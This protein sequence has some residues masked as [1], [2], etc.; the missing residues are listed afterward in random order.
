LLFGGVLRRTLSEILFIYRPD[1][2]AVVRIALA[3]SH[4]VLCSPALKA[5]RY[6]FPG[7]SQNVL[8]YNLGTRC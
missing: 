2:P 8:T 5:F 1:A 4:K 3:P 7:P 6:Q